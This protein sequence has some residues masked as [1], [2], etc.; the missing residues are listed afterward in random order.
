LREAAGSS[1]AARYQVWAIAF[2]AITTT[3]K[4]CGVPLSV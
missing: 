2:D 1:R 3:P 4:S